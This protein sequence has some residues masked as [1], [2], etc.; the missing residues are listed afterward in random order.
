MGMD[1]GAQSEQ[2]RHSFAVAGSVSDCAL[3]T[4]TE[5]MNKLPAIGRE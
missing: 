2:A 3:S 5:L 4:K 1:N